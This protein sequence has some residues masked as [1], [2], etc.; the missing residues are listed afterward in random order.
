MND[1]KV[2]IIFDQVLNLMSNLLW[3]SYSSK[4]MA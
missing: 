3:L 1:G 4:Q 2:L